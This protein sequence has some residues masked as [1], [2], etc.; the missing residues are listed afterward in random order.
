MSLMNEYILKQLGGKDLEEELKR[1]I[2]E[3]NKLR[4]SFLLIY[5]AALDKD[6][7][8]ISLSTDDYHV[9]FDILRNDQHKKIDVYIETPGGS[10]EAAEEI[11]RLLHSKYTDGVSF[12]VSGDAKSAGT[13]MV[14]SGDEIIMTKSG[15]L[16]PIDA[17]VMIGRHRVSAYDY[18]Q[19]VVEKWQEA[20]TTSRLNPADAMMIAQI[21]PG[22]LSGVNHSLQMAKD[23]LKEWLP[24]YK[25]R[26]WHFTETRHIPVTDKMKADR[27]NEIADQLLD[28]AKWRSHGRSLKLED[29]ESMGLRITD[30]DKN[31]ALAEIIYRIQIVSKLLFATTSTFKIFMTDTIKIFKQAST[32]QHLLQNPIPTLDPLSKA[33]VINIKLPCPKCGKEQG[34]YLKFKNNPNSER[35]SKSQGF[36]PYPK[37]GKHRCTCGFEIDLVTIKNDIET[38]KHARAIF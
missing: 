1:L 9:I 24:K 13:I 11:V 3:Y 31:D 4:G 12:V 30:A 16:G 28:H 33:D 27:A 35:T 14:L 37:S 8:T 23:L 22:E 36:I 38:K 19:W 15:S 20:N 7:P 5:A 2:I 29:L 34:F 26:Q 25:F 6:I 21:S 32:Q 10:G 18:M 17:Q